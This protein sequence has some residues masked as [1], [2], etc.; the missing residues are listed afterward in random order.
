MVP[1]YRAYRAYGGR[2]YQRRAYV[3]P[4]GYRPS[5][6]RPGWNVN[7]YFGRPYGG[8]Y[9]YRDRSYGY[10]SFS[11]GLVYGALRIVDAPRDARV[12]VDGYYAGE[13]DDY[14][15]IFQRLNL[16]AGAHQI[17]VEVEPGLEPLAFDVRIAPGETVTIHVDG[18]Y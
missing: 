18:R 15:G 10:Y 5:G 11:P 4:Y 3:A 6:Y 13:V 8:G 9:A 1:S 12:F 17:E 2:S 16:E 14:D 7:L